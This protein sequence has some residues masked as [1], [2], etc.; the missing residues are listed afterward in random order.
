[1]ANAEVNRK[2]TK[3]NLHSLEALAAYDSTTSSKI[4]RGRMRQAG[5]TRAMEM[6]AKAGFVS[7]PG[8]NDIREGDQRADA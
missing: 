3:S 8:S 4:W 7:L 5:D 2:F 6:W 1:M